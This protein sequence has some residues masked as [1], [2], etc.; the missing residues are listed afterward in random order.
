MSN[1]RLLATLLRP[2]PPCLLA[3]IAILATGCQCIIFSADTPLIEASRKGDL[4]AVKL[5]VEKGADVNA[6]GEAWYGPLHCACENQHVDVAV[7]LLA[8]G[9][10]VNIYSHHKPLHYVAMNGNITLAEILYAYGA[11]IN[12]K[13]ID[14]GTPLFVAVVDRQLPMVQ[15][16]LSR[17]ADPNI[18]AIYDRTPLQVAAKRNDLT[19]GKLLLASG[20]DPNSVSEDFLIECGR[21]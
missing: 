12:A 2:V 14:G 15:W 9:A 19:I 16:L 17:G 13:G 21:K 20:A 6:K 5:L 3:L 1:R 8:S 10:D 7:Y 18:A 4:D 11:D